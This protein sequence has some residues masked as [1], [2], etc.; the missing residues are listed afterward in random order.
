VVAATGASIPARVVHHS[1]H[2]LLEE[3]SGALTERATRDP[4]RTFSN[5]CH[6]VE[7]ELE[8][9]VE[10][11]GVALPD[12]SSPRMVGAASAPSATSPPP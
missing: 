3:S 12:S 2:L 4:G 5:A 6:A 7:L 8:V 11:G 1:G 10:T 9:D